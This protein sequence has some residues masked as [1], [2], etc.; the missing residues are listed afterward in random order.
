MMFTFLAT[1]YEGT[2]LEQSPEG[3]ISWHKKEDVLKSVH[4]S[5]ERL[6]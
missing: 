4:D 5:I 3:I 6:F 2:N 1:D